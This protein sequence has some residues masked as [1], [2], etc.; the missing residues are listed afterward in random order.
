MMR[1]YVCLGVALAFVGGLFTLPACY[2]LPRPV[3][4]FR[5]GAL[6]ECPEDYTCGDDSR[7][8]LNGSAPMVCGTPDAPDLDAAV[9]VIDGPPDDAIDAPPDAEIDAAIDA[10]VDAAIDAPAD[11]A[12]DAAIDAPDDAPPD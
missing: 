9:D 1:R 8:H 10:A 11:A 4:G 12:L 7:C 2:D 3:C 5:C 6:G